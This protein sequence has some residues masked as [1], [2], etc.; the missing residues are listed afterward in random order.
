MLPRLV[1]AKRGRPPIPSPMI[2]EFRYKTGEVV[3]LGDSV[4]LKSMFFFKDRGEVI[5]V[6]GVSPFHPDMKNG[7]IEYIGVKLDGGATGAAT[8]D[9][10]TNQVLHLRFIGRRNFESKDALDPN[11]AVFEDDKPEE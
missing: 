2:E 1:Q 8:V 11:R 5:Y 3:T 9:P 6:P 7:E 10:T 4:V